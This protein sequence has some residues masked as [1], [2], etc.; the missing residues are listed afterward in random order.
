[1]SNRN[2]ESNA[3][4]FSVNRVVILMARIYAIAMLIAA[5]EVAINIFGQLPLL[6]PIF[7]YGAIAIS[8]VAHVALTWTAFSTDRPEIGQR[9]HAL[10]SL[11]LLV[12]WPLQVSDSASL[13]EFFQPWIWWVIG[14][15]A[16]A[17]A[18]SLRWFISVPL[19]FASPI[20][21]FFLHQTPEGGN[22]TALRS[23]QDSFYIFLIS[24]AFALILWLL[25][26]TAQQADEA[27]QNLATAL[28]KQAAT[29][30]AEKERSRV[31]ALIHDRVLTALIVASK[32][33]TKEE[34]TQA[35]KL[36]GA[37]LT[38]LGQTKLGGQS[39]KEISLVSFF[40]SVEELVRQA[41]PEFKISVA[42]T[43]DFLIPVEVADAFTE[44]TLQAATNTQQHAKSATE[45]DLFLRGNRTGF[46]VV[47]RDDGPGFRPGRVPK[48]RLGL[49]MSIIGRVEDVGGKVFIDSLP[50][51]G[52]TLV[53]TW[54]SDAD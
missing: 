35:K 51:K 45:R 37:A 27:N 39:A 52:T 28:A 26:Y 38:S 43:N 47:V 20:V 42:E 33:N 53:L 8:V 15:A 17:G 23:I 31:G 30:A 44:A 16:I 25:R 6:D 22:A 50:G 7:G 19:L 48:T 9:V 11:G 54:S 1:M 14:G 49:R 34:I 29:D 36:A 46:K 3:R 18:L 10:T 12:T 41:A 24:T 13:P 40:A 21:W 4:T 2:R 32:A 5:V